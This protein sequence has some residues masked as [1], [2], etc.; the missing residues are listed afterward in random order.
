M[1]GPETVKDIISVQEVPSPPISCGRDVK[2]L[3]SSRNS[4]VVLIVDAQFR[5]FVLYFT[6]FLKL[7][8]KS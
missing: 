5:I 7:T 1:A 6:M 8:T 4:P 2:A 3:F